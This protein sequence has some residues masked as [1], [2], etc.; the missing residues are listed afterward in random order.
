MII[1]LGDGLRKRLKY[2]VSASAVALIRSRV[3]AVRPTNSYESRTSHR[4]GDVG[5]PC[6]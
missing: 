1:A 4:R 5:E 2:V 3:N 6:R